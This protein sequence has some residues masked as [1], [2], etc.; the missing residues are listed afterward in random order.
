MLNVFEPC[1]LQLGDRNHYTLKP[2]DIIMM[3]D[4]WRRLEKES[5]LG[6]EGEP[7]N[8]KSKKNRRLKKNAAKSKTQD[9]DDDDDEKVSQDQQCDNQ[10]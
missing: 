7:T 10:V 2:D 6:I 3:R 9:V 1:T 8:T 4:E 5:F